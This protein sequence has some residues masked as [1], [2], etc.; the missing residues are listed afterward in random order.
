MAEKLALLPRK[1]EDPQ[2]P[3]QVLEGL[4]KHPRRWLSTIFMPLSV[5]IPCQLQA[6]CPDLCFVPEVAFEV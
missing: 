6:P 1:L 4:H 3:E 5:L 2:K